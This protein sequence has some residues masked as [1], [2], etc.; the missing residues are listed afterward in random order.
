VVTRLFLD[1]KLHFAWSGSKA[2][3]IF[4]YSLATWTATLGSAAFSQCD[5]LIVGGML[6][7]PILGVYSAITGITSKINSFSG[8]AVQPLVPWLSR[9]VAMNASA[10]ARIRQAVHLNAIIAIWSGIFLYVMADWV[11][12]IVIPGGGGSR[13]ILGL[14]IAAVIY[15]LYSLN[16]PGHFILFAVGRPQTNAVVTM[17]GALVSLALIFVGARYFGLLGAVAGN[18]GYLLLFVLTTSGL[19]KVRIP[20]LHYVTWIA[21]PLMGL[22]VAAL[23]GWFLRDYFWWRVGFVTLQGA[24]FSLW[25][26]H[27][28][29]D[30]NWIRFDLGH[31]SES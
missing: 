15:A 1:H 31:V 13:E 4:R 20:L 24:A 7:A 11:M 23:V 10:E 27:T 21:F 8:T 19:R 5:R 2:R 12:R 14:Q 29:A 16:A 30:A 25:F 3:Q 26:L 6:G 17:S 18:A 28:H 9:D 22:V